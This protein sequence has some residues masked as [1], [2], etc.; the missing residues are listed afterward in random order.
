MDIFQ[1]NKDVMVSRDTSP[2]PTA[3]CP[4]IHG[5]AAELPGGLQRPPHRQPPRRGQRQ[6][7][8]GSLPFGG[9]GGP[10]LYPVSPDFSHV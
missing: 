7:P 6:P 4:A 9:H 1:Q 2:P 8:A 3:L 10:Q 5:P